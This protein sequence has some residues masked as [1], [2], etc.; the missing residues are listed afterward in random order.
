M[1]VAVEGKELVVVVVSFAFKPSLLLFVVLHFVSFSWSLCGGSDD[2]DDDD[3]DVVVV[4]DVEVPA[5]DVVCSF[6]SLAPSSSFCFGTGLFSAAA[7][8]AAS[9]NFL[10][11]FRCPPCFQCCT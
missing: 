6:P 5:V 3:D 1:E 2:D 9:L 7:A 11:S 10:H 8:A 4:V